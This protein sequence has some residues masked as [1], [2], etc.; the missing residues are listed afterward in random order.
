M[1][2]STAQHPHVP[3]T[4][5]CNKNIQNIPTDG[6]WASPSLDCLA[7]G[8]YAFWRTSYWQN[9][10]LYDLGRL[11]LPICAGLPTPIYRAPQR[12][13]LQ[14]PR[15]LKRYNKVLP[16]EHTR[17]RL[18]TRPYDFQL[19]TIGPNQSALQGIRDPRTP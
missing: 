2:H 3:T 14:D 7:P 10:P 13:T 16:Q 18:G 15:V 11:L 12:L 1:Q 6:I 4:A 19:A 9:G 17:L 8:Y 5:T